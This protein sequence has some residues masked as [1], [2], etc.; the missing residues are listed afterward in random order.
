MKTIS[1]VNLKGGVGKTTTAVNMAAILAERSKRVLLI[2]AD[3]QY[4]LSLHMRA[5]LGG[6]TICTLLDRDEPYYK[7]LVQPTYLRNVDIIPGSLNLMQYDLAMLLG[8]DNS[9][10]A[11]RSLCETVA[12]DDAYDYVIIDCP[13]SFSAACAAAIF[14]SDEVIIPTTIGRYEQEGIGNL[15][16]QIDGMR[17]LNP[18][19]RIAGVLITNYHAAPLILQGVTYLRIHLPVNVFDTVIPR[20]DKV[21]E[22]AYAL[23]P[24][25]IYSPTSGAARK[26]RQF[27]TE[28]LGG[29]DDGEV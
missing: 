26:Y 13:P 20:T 27:I 15:I 11:I 22:S 12:E 9:R 25:T 8:K 2:D 5:D 19:L 24:V 28:Y 23:D 10:A 16:A 14:A 3:G 29:V 1:I 18:N 7:N 21:G 4:N 17:S 6:S